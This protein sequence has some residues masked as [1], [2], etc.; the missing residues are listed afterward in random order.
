E[1]GEEPP[2]RPPRKCSDCGKRLDRQR[3]KHKGTQ[4]A[5][6]LG[7]EA[8]EDPPRPFGCEGCGKSFNRSSHHLAHRCPRSGERPHA[9]P[10]CQRRFRW[11]S[12]LARHRLAHARR[13]K[14]ET[15]AKSQPGD[16]GKGGKA[17]ACGKSFD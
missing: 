11:A 3:F 1:G 5:P 10:E 16:A 7:A 8:A 12:A 4:T 17:A 15:G 2:P 13:E 9:C 6:P 14:A